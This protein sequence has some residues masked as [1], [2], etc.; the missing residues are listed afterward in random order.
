MFSSISR[1]RGNTTMITIPLLE[2]HLTANMTLKLLLVSQHSIM[3]TS[4]G[5]ISTD[6][7]L[8]STENLINIL[9]TL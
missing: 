5:N 7:G 1:R 8:P 2:A 9:K 3:H 6:V 4:S